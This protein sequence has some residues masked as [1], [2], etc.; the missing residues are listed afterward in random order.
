MKRVRVRIQLTSVT[1]HIL[2]ICFPSTLGGGG[3]VSRVEGYLFVLFIRVELLTNTV[4]TFFPIIYRTK[5]QISRKRVYV[6]RLNLYP[7]LYLYFL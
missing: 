1:H 4:Y 3:G 2:L 5:C 7:Y 6:V